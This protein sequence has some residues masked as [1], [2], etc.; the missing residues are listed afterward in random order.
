[1][2]VQLQILLENGHIALIDLD[3]EIVI[4]DRSWWQDTDFFVGT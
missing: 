2:L 3:E 4:T 1:M